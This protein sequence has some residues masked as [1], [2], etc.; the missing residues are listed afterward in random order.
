MSLAQETQ[1]NFF[2]KLKGVYP[3]QQ[4]SNNVATV[5]EISVGEAY[6]KISGK[7]F[8]SIEQI[9]LLSDYFKVGTTRNGPRCG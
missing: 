2:E 5:L 3:E 4:L 7:S 6:K 9:V 8:I 1:R